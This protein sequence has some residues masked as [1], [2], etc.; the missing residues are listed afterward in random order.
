MSIEWWVALSHFAGRGYGA[1]SLVLLYWIGASEI[2]DSSWGWWTAGGLPSVRCLG[3]WNILLW[4]ELVITWS[5][6]YK[7][8]MI[9]TSLLIARFLRLMLKYSKVDADIIDT[10]WS[11]NDGIC[12]IT[13]RC[14]TPHTPLPSDPGQVKTAS[15]GSE[16][17]S[18]IFCVAKSKLLKILGYVKS[19]TEVLSLG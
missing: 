6:S 9:N 12:Y 16:F 1:W 13:F 10:N 11:W 8:L 19:C 2:A 18:S 17:F 4:C 7:I 3:E 15:W 14:R 5:V